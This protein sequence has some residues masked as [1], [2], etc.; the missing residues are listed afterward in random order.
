MKKFV[1]LLLMVT[2]VVS[3]TAFAE[4]KLKVTE[5]NLL[6]FAGDDNGYFYAKVENVGDK[7]IGVGSGNLVIFSEDDDI[8]VTESYVTTMPSYVLLEPGE[9]LYMK[10]FLWNSALKNTPVGD[11]KFSMQTRNSQTAVEKFECEASFELE[12]ANSYNNYVY[13]TFTNSI[14]IP[15]Y[16]F[17]I[18]AALHDEDGNLVFADSKSLSS[19]AIHPGS[20]VTVKLYVD[21]DLMEHYEANGIVPASVDAMVFCEND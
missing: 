21:R 16:D 19:I 5:K 1:V 6:V 12:G 3:S 13:V 8:L 4:G 9:S 17:Y 14:D 20:S 15:L 18:V 2:L 11:Y 7:A 10:E